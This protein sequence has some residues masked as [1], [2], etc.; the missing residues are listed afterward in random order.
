MANQSK[1]AEGARAIAADAFRRHLRTV[2]ASLSTVMPAVEKGAQ[3]LLD[4]VKNNRRL[5]VCG[6]GGS[7]ADSQHF[8]GEWLSRYKADR[9]P[10]PATALT[11][12]TSSLTSIG[13]DYDFE[14][15]FSRQ[16]QALGS[17]KDIL[18]AFT[19]SGKSKNILKAI[20]QAKA[21]GLAVVVLTG[22]GGRELEALADVAVVVPSLETARIQEVHE[23]VHHI[24]CEFLD[25]ELLTT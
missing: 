20:E 19:T 21:Q 6:N 25:S 24:W 10:L 17:P 4:L 12:D 23:L 18:V 16:V 14:H 1:R 13:N 7:A 3:L 22:E 9:R 2:E 8:A 15:I 11:T 5:L